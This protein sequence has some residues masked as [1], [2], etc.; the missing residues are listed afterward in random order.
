MK[1]IETFMKDGF[2]IGNLEDYQDIFDYKTFKS[3][4]N[5]I[6]K[7]DL[8]ENS[9]FIYEYTIRGAIGEQ[10]NETLVYHKVRSNHF[11]DCAC[12]ISDVENLANLGNKHHDVC[13]TSGES[14]TKDMADKVFKIHLNHQINKMNDPSVEPFWVFGQSDSLMKKHKRFILEEQIKFAK[15][16]YSQYKNKKIKIKENKYLFTADTH[17]NIYDRGCM[18]KS[19]RDGAP[20]DRICSFV[21]FMNE[22]WDE[23]NGGRLIIRSE[24]K[25]VITV[26]AE[27]PN[28]VVLDQIYSDVYHEL[29]KVKS[30]LKASIV[31]FLH[32]STIIGYSGEKGLF[33]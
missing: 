12:D 21:F 10:I 4:S 11:R 13:V 5:E 27:L 17:L 7:T 24:D 25:P 15:H 31:S 29:E 2:L 8:Y 3:I 9:R 16:Y 6:N 30:D 19:H 22:K 14:L 28:F 26:N 20:V 23:E 18:I 33:Y 32:D 1:D